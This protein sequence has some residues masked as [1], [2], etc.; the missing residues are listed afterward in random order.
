MVVLGLA[1]CSQAGSDEGPDDPPGASTSTGRVDGG[2][3]TTGPGPA[4]DGS[5]DMTADG[6]GFIAMG[7]LASGL[8]CSLF[9]QDCPAGDKCMPW[10]GPR[11]TQWDRTR[12]VPVAPDPAPV[13]EPCE[14]EVSTRSGVDDCDRGAIC[15]HVDPTTLE[16]ICEA[17]CTG[18]PT[19]PTCEDP[20]SV[21]G[22]VTGGFVATCLR[23]CDPL[24]IDCPAD[25][26]CAHDLQ[27]FVCTPDAS[28]P[29]GEAG[30]PCEHATHCDPGLAC[31]PP[32][33]VPECV[34]PVGCCSQYCSVDDPA[35]PCLVGQVCAL[36][37]EEGTAPPGYESLGVCI[38]PA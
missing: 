36:Y 33:L 21:C 5:V 18:S 7:D 15:W 25:Q 34:D 14:V 24:V 37:F 2:E 22:F 30:D 3:T 26:T 32:E 31:I 23:T 1:G 4:D 10:A 38:V 11:G 35:P 16:G 28:G 8:E 29:S 9:E 6:S 20:S 17:L 13:G 12:C 19:E 27:E